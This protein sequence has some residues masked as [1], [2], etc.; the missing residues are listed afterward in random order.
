M[1][2]IKIQC[3]NCSA[4]NRR[5]ELFA[6]ANK[7]LHLCEECAAVAR[8]LQKKAAEKQIERKQR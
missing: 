6:F 8:L 1:R 2:H 4:K 7:T 3:D 5:V